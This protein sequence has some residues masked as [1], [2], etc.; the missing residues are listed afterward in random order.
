M[1]A[2]HSLQANKLLENANLN[3]LGALLVKQL[4]GETRVLSVIALDRKGRKF[5]NCT[6]V[7]P[8]FETKGN[9]NIKVENTVEINK[10]NSITT[11]VQQ[12]LDLISLK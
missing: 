6:A 11:F 5:T 3:K 10:F 2:A 8:T 9:G 4:D 7:F 12:N 1:R